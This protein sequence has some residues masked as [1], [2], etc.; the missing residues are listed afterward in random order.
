[1]VHSLRA[2]GS[3]AWTCSQAF[4]DGKQV[5]IPRSDLLAWL[6]SR[7]YPD[8]NVAVTD[9]NPDA[10]RGAR[11]RKHDAKEKVKRFV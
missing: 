6:E 1:L 3:F 7:R 5:Y 2:A 10:P 11:R 4:F 8:S 9:G